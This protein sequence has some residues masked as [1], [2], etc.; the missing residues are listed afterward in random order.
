MIHFSI[1]G[2]AFD[3][4]FFSFESCLPK[5]L[6]KFGCEVGDLNFI[7]V[8]QSELLHINKKYLNHE[9]NTDVIT[10]D[11]SE[12]SVVSADIYIGVYQVQRNAQEYDE[13]F[14]EEMTRVMIHGVLHCMGYSDKTAKTAQDMRDQENKFI[15]YFSAFLVKELA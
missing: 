6:E 5:F 11:D 2:N 8:S 12:G 14:F 4:P 1:K 3:F 15:S 10:F 13:T 9:Y 7:Y